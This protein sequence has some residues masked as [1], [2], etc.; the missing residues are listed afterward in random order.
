MAQVHL[1]FTCIEYKFLVVFVDGIVGEMN[2][3]IFQVFLFCFL[4]GL[5]GKTGQTLLIDVYS[6]RIHTVYEHVDAHIKFKTLNE[7]RIVYVDLNDP[8]FPFYLLEIRNEANPFALRWS[9]GL[10][11]VYFVLFFWVLSIIPH[12]LSHLWRNWPGGGEK[13]VLFGEGFAHFHQTSPQ[14]IF[15]WENLYRREM[16]YFLMVV[17]SKQ[18]LSFDVVVSP[19]DIPF[20]WFFR[21]LSDPAKFF[22]DGLDYI[23]VGFLVKWCLLERLTTI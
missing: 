20:L 15:L 18:I 10:E 3:I 17:K 23:V 13:I 14:E 9:F 4:V 19:H 7:V 5:S 6:H 22:N 16:A 12:Q 1:F 21:I 2:K 11:Y 8:C